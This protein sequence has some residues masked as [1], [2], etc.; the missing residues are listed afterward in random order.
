[1]INVAD[2]AAQERDKYAEIWSLREYRDAHSP[3][4]ENVERFMKV[5]HPRQGSTTIDVGCGS[6][7]AGL[8]L[9]RRGLFSWYLDITDAGLDQTVP[10][11]YF[12]QQPAWAK[13]PGKYFDYGFCCDVLE[14]IPPEYALLVCDRIIDRCGVAWLQICNQPDNFGP[15]LL[16]EPLHLT[17]R[18]YSWWLMR[19][20]TLGNVIDA[21]DL[22]G[23]SL[24]VV[25]R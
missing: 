16:G 15:K 12:I 10:R 23:V 19:L 11:E 1:M 22:C 13:W 17:V 14:H 4:V 9:A 5:M 18:T 20:A 21:R 3:G 24:F 25:T 2:G 7:H 6:G 8:E